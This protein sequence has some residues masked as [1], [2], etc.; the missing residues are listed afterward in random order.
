[1]IK[2]TK[3]MVQC[4]DQTWN[5]PDARG[6]AAAVSTDHLQPKHTFGASGATEE[7]VTTGQRSRG[8]QV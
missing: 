4:F 3:N 2:A 7:E 5:P 8:G 6:A 1:M